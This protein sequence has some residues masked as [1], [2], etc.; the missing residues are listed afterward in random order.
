MHHTQEGQSIKR[1]FAEPYWTFTLNHAT[2]WNSIDF[3]SL[4]LLWECRL[5]C[6]SELNSPSKFISWGTLY[7]FLRW[8]I[9][10]RIVNVSLTNSN[11]SGVI[12]KLLPPVAWGVAATA[13]KM[14]FCQEKELIWHFQ[15]ATCDSFGMGTPVYCDSAIFIY[16]R[17]AMTIW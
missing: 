5:A 11:G 15:T 14:Q 3:P 12:T 17:L 6:P 10:Q 7:G 1:W 9:W 4:E 8:S 13:T 16:W 2:D